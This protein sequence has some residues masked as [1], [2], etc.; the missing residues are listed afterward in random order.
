MSEHSFVS[1]SAHTAAV[2]AKDKD[3]E[4]LS[5][6]KKEPEAFVATKPVTAINPKKKSG[7][8]TTLLANYIS[9]STGTIHGPPSLS[10]KAE[11]KLSPSLQKTLVPTSAT[12]AITVGKPSVTAVLKPTQKTVIQTA[13]TSTTI[14][15]SSGTIITQGSSSGKTA[16]QG[17]SGS[18][19]K[20][21][22]V[23]KA[24]VGATTSGRKVPQ[25]GALQQ[26]KQGFPKSAVVVPKQTS[27][28][29][30]ISS[31]SSNAQ[32]GIQ[33]V[34]TGPKD[35]TTATPATS[36]PTLLTAE[37]LSIL[38]MPQL[39]QS[40][41]TVIPQLPVSQTSASSSSTSAATQTQPSVYLPGQAILQFVQS[42]K[43]NSTAVSTSPKPAI[44]MSHQT[45]LV[46]SVVASKSHH[47]L[48]SMVKSAPPVGPQTT[49]LAVNSRASSPTLTIQKRASFS[50]SNKLP[51][52]P[53]STSPSKPASGMSS[54]LSS[55]SVR[56]TPP[57][58]K[59]H[60]ARTDPIALSSTPVVYQS[61]PKA[62]T[63]A[64][65][66]HP[67]KLTLTKVKPSVGLGMSRESPSFFHTVTSPSNSGL[68]SPVEQIFEE[69]SYG[70]YPIPQVSVVQ[71]QANMT[72]GTSQR[73]KEGTNFP[74]LLLAGQ[75][76]TT[77]STVGGGV[78]ASTGG[79]GMMSSSA[80]S[81]SGGG[82]MSSS[83]AGGVISSLGGGGMT[84]HAGGM[85]SS[86][87]GG[88]M[89]SSVAGGMT[90]LQ[91]NQVSS[92]RIGSTSYVIVATT[93]DNSSNTPK[94]P[95]Q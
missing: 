84:V 65:Q 33:V 56:T 42:S 27:G 48:T 73:E 62:N 26:L 59:S 39:L 54:S 81:F 24:I 7:A 70:S 5:V 91:Q 32:I 72:S 41:V 15:K 90:S 78:T 89:S 14:A 49:K 25:V 95:L 9:T 43:A 31:S 77:T 2:L 38:L 69:H 93:A 80:S 51:A 57:P 87:G 61:L 28:Q 47:S 8:Q 40:H 74:L 55:T 16:V 94:P 19:S 13:S 12:R 63:P 45:S 35:T 64:G 79:G 17:V 11:L 44:S 86:L 88:M 1:A 30:P 4:K 82:M 20:I 85:T 22:S 29:K 92:A 76:G 68:K 37:Q 66:T 36:S 10:P 3:K 34:K 21:T 18:L 83:V 50:A 46:D 67:L 23:G 53:T 71:T 52:K 6:V 58:V 60:V 75:S